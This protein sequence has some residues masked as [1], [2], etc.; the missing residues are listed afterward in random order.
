LET[1]GGDAEEVSEPSEEAPEVHSEGTVDTTTVN[2][3]FNSQPMLPGANL[4]Q[5]QM[6]MAMQNGMMP[7]FGGFPMGKLA[8]VRQC[9]FGKAFFDVLQV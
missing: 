6:M 9:I 1:S 4:N 5:M 7:G 2:N 3:G 8:V